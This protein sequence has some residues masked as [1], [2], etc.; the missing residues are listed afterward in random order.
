MG[1]HPSIEELAAYA[2]NLL[3]ADA[4]GAIDLHLRSCGACLREI[5]LVRSM[6]DLELAGR[7][8][9]PPAAIQ[10]K[11][12]APWRARLA[13]ISDGAKGMLGSLAEG[14]E[15]GIGLL[16][17]SAAI[18]FG[19][20]GVPGVPQ[21]AHFPGSVAFKMP[22]SSGHELHLG[23]AP[24]APDIHLDG[25]TL[26][27]HFTGDVPKEVGLMV[28]GHRVVQTVNS[29][30]NVEFDLPQHLS[31]A[32]GETAA[33][34]P[35]PFHGELVLEFFADDQ[36]DSVRLPGADASM[37]TTGDSNLSNPADIHMDHFYSIQR[38][39]IWTTERAHEHPSHDLPPDS[40]PSGDSVDPNADP[41]SHGDV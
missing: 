17:G 39:G 23:G 37:D 15:A 10:K 6:H 24:G 12:G 31:H 40:L 36:A 21:P 8:S 34:G 4:K 16:A 3:L 11:A 38:D 28:G 7:L 25:G 29:S 33:H 18:L 22:T 5:A 30:G 20:H 13:I 9:I 32:H 35:V 2:D 27:L 41:H 19:S 1:D 26:H 14:A